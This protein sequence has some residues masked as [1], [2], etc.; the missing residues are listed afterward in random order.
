MAV[1]LPS[2]K[3]TGWT[4]CQQ[5]H[6]AVQNMMKSSVDEMR[7]QSESEH[8]LFRSLAVGGVFQIKGEVDDSHLDGKA[9]LFTVC[10]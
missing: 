1:I 10:V 2:L 5:E 7:N 6:G 8:S 9:K 3:E 4:S